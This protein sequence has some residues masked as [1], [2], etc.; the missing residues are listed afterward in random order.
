MGFLCSDLTVN[1]STNHSRHFHICIPR[2][3]LL[4][5]NGIRLFSVMRNVLHYHF[6]LN[7]THHFNDFMC[8]EDIPNDHSQMLRISIFN[9]MNGTP[10]VSE[11]LFTLCQSGLGNHSDIN[12]A[13]TALSL[14]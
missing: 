2:V 1:F 10:L 9:R 12:P 4:S 13:V 14:N 8:V 5:T 11:W 6:V 7:C 3:G